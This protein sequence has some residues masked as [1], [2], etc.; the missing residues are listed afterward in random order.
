MRRHIARAA[1]IGVVTPG[2]A[3]VAATLEED[4]VALAGSEEPGRHPDAREAGADDDDA[5]VVHDVGP[6]PL[7]GDL[8]NVD[9]CH[10]RLL[11]AS[12]P[13]RCDPPHSRRQ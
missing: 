1:G 6:S 10:I 4:E 13:L 2:A 7:I 11:P 9:K 5:M 12:T 8:C 3:D